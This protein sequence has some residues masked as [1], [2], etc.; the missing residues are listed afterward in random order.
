MENLVHTLKS[1]MCIGGSNL[2]DGRIL[3]EGVC[4]P[5][6][7][8]PEPGRDGDPALVLSVSIWEQVQFI[9]CC[10][11]NL[12]RIRIKL[13]AVHHSCSNFRCPRRYEQCSG[14]RVSGFGFRV[15]DF[16]SQ[17]SGSTFGF[18]VSGFR[19]RISGFGFRASVFGCWASGF[20]FW[21]SGKPALQSSEKVR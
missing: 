11:R 12:L 16:G 15:S 14:F 9:S 19:F 7:Q 2:S 4:R 3:V 1:H 17:V 10:L 6:R 18:R 13:V 21:V 20:G 5:L 8:G